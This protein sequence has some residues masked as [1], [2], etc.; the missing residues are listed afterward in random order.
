[1]VILFHSSVSVYF[2][3]EQVTGRGLVSMRF[4]GKAT[5]THVEFVD[6]TNGTGSFI[7]SFR[8]ILQQDFYVSLGSHLR[9]GI[10][11]YVVNVFAR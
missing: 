2:F 11:D 10:I 7:R 3:S 1:M 9:N 5:I 8:G 4:N 6:Q